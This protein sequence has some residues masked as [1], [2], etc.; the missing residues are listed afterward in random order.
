MIEI[1]ANKRTNYFVTEF[2]S[3]YSS[4]IAN[5]AFPY[6]ALH[7][8]TAYLTS[9][10]IQCVQLYKL[11]KATYISLGVPSE[12]STQENSKKMVS[13][14]NWEELA[15][16][17]SSIAMSTF[18]PKV[19][20][21]ISSG[22]SIA[23]HIEQC[24]QANSGQERNEACY[25]ILLEVIYLLSIY[26]KAPIWIALSLVAQALDDVLK[27][28]KHYQE[29]QI[30]EMLSSV[31]LAGIRGNKASYYVE[32]FL[33][34]RTEGM[35]F[36]QILEGENTFYN[37][38]DYLVKTKEELAQHELSPITYRS[39]TKDKG[40][41]VFGL[42]P[43]HTL[44]AKFAF[45]PASNPKMMGY[46][47]NYADKSRKQISLTEDWKYKRIT[48]CFDRQ[49]VDVMIIG[50]PSTLHNKKWVLVSNGNGEFYEDQLSC[51]LEFKNFLSKL[52]GNGIVF[53]YPDVGSS[54]GWANRFAMRKAY[55]AVLSFLEDQKQGIA[56]KEIIG[57]GH[58]IGGGVQ[59]DALRWHKLQENIS[60]LF[61]KSR[62]FSI[63]SQIAAQIIAVLTRNKY[64]GNFVQVAVQGI[65]W[66]LGSVDSS[67]ELQA[68]EIVLQTARV[69]SYEIL[70]DSQ[71]IIHDGVIPAETSLAKAL[72][73]DPS[74]PKGNKVFVGIPERHNMPLRDL[75]FIVDL[76][77]SLTKM[78]P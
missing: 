75:S 29:G 10:G 64:I 45:L 77:N 49:K 66:D 3:D 5:I 54:E 39:H 58:S 14:K 23:R 62:T 41:T 47:E 19:Q 18:F 16:L 48:I 70:T 43:L 63:M 65:G 13:N 55:Q 78:R 33:D 8:T 20:S 35:P 67:K 53:N 40:W 6:L 22:L 71:K 4:R 34:S 60:Y 30:P 59:G 69:R 21:F 32:D 68:P 42:S 50:K 1:N 31:L 17:V 15:V 56:A 61:I 11:G 46:P 73:D 26:Q 27:A 28:R 57:Y 51:S 44:A 37:Q 7:P 2:I 12:I 24:I 76:I 36:W 38:P 52:N 9:A 74:C 72:L 25:Q